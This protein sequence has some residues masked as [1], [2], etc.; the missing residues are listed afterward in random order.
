MKFKIDLENIKN[1]FRHIYNNLKNVI[2]KINWSEAAVTAVI[3]ILIGFI[4]IP[5]VNKCII[6]GN[7]NKCS[8]KMYLLITQLS[9]HL[10]EE[11]DG[12]EWHDM[13]LNGHSDEALE[14]L[15]DEVKENKNWNIKSSDYYFEINGNELIL[16]CKKHKDITDRSILLANVEDDNDKDIGILGWNT[17]ELREIKEIKTLGDD[18]LILDAGKAGKYCLAAWSWDD[19]VKETKAEG[20]KVFGASIVLY[21]GAYYYYPDGFRI[22]KNAEN[23]N[24]FKYAEDL[25]DSKEGAYCIPFDTDSVSNER[26]SPDNHEG[27][28]MVEEDTIYIWQSQASRE[29]SKGWIKV[30]CEYKKL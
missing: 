24:P 7:K 11:P 12:G 4:I 1:T 26:F 13:I 2:K 16:R 27:S 23:S 15:A 30:Y 22:R 17:N 3:I 8:S 6:N 19:Y 5:S 14:I 25:E 18:A 20:D 10:A 29:L 28:L 21:D 9:N